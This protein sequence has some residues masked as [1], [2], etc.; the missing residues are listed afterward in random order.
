MT[1]D[2]RNIAI[3]AH[4]DHGKTTLIDS[5][6]KQSGVFRNNQTMTERLMDSNDLEK[7]RGITILSKCTAITVHDENEQ[8][9]RLN[10]IDTPGHADFG[11]EVERVLSMSN[12]V[13][14]L[15]DSAEGVMPQ[16]KFVLSK[17]LKANLK[18][19]VVVNKIDKQDARAN[20]VVDEI[21]E[22]LITLDATDDQL[23]CPVLYASGRNGWCVCSL[24]KD[25][26]D[27]LKPLFNTI[28]KTIKHPKYDYNA[29]FKML[30]T[31]LDS[32]QFMGKMLIGKI[33]Q[34]TIA[35]NTS[36]KAI[37]LNGE[38]IEQGR[39]TKLFRFEGIKKVPTEKAVA[40]DII[41]VSGME[42]ASVSDTIADIKITTPLE[43]KP[44]DP[45][46]MSITIAVNDSPLA[47]QEG[48]KLT[49]RAIKDRL[50]KE[51]ETNVA[52]KIE[53]L[54]DKEAFKVSGRGELQL[55]VLIETMR[56]E[57][58]ELSISRP[59]VLFKKDETTNQILEPVEEVIIDVDEEFSGSVIEKMNSRKGIMLDMKTTSQNK[60]RLSFIIPSRCLIGYHSEFLTDTRGTGVINKIF[61]GYKAHKGSMGYKR[62]GAL[63]S[64]EKGAVTAYSLNNIQ[65]RGKLF[66]RPQD[67][68]YQGMVVGIHS[69]DSD[70]EV[71]PIKGKQLTNMRASG[72]DEMIKLSPPVLFSLEEMISFI[73]D[74]ELVE[75]TPKGLRMRKKYLD[76]NE[77][78]RMSRSSKKDY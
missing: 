48:D 47:G 9:V 51:A 58:Y 41:A 39:L 19:I 44:I 37:N 77:R 49:S 38:T 30:V 15:V 1:N 28:I 43:T 22:L 17:A 27:N 63:I 16:T 34:G 24:E 52:I 14:L 59:K 67:V 78:K 4:V 21:I 55:G 11:G 61:H 56:R 62:K 46:T 32:D 7:E 57:G 65:E 75:V 3:I 8:E 53:E 31:M 23:N 35:V 70:L 66:V 13:L 12:G 26:R 33:Y 42:K 64:T 36:I 20:E 29:P 73:E 76:P 60:T 10:I 5:M 74:D 54:D 71:N 50:I 45:P 40:G 69:R 6:F 2:I 68:V 18:P 72:T 25:P